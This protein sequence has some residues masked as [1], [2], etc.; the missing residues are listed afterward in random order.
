MASEREAPAALR[1]GVV[2]LTQLGSDL[3]C[4]KILQAT[5]ATFLQW[6]PSS[7]SHDATFGRHHRHTYFPRL[8]LTVDSDIPTEE[9]E[10]LYSPNT[11]YP[12]QTGEVL[13]S[14]YQRAG[15]L[16]YGGYSTVWLCRDLVCVLRPV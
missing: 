3:S 5:T 1:T 16:G 11:F 12:G 2:A 13:N 15:K 7:V 14:R 8:D 6:R 10:P 4:F 9:R